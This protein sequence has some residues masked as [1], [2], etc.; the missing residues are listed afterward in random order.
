MLWSFIV[1]VPDP[2]GAHRVERFR[3]R[4]QP[5]PV[6][7]AE[8]NR[9][10]SRRARRQEGGVQVQR[11]RRILWRAGPITMS[12]EQRPTNSTYRAEKQELAACPLPHGSDA[13]P[14]GCNRWC[15]AA[16]SADAWAAWISPDAPWGLGL[17]LRY[18][19]TSPCPIDGPQI[20]GAVQ[21]PMRRRRCDLPQ[22]CLDGRSSAEAR[23]GSNASFSCGS[24]CVLGKEPSHH[25]RSATGEPA[26][27]A[28]LTMS[29]EARFCPQ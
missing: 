8:G 16:G 15:P 14:A 19:E 13:C 2:V 9:E 11:G 20:T 7:S 3:H 6:R 25:E 21:A 1:Q 28:V 18:P 22:A 12:H 5:D 24:G 10:G 27:V 26:F 29:R 4:R 17:L 23:D